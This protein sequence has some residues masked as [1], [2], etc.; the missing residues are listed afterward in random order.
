M[1]HILLHQYVLIKKPKELLMSYARDSN[2]LY[3]VGERTDTAFQRVTKD[4]HFSEE[5]H[6]V[7]KGHVSCCGCVPSSKLLVERR[8]DPM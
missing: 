7:T 5:C 2:H 6:D 1:F 3:D 8:R 4:A